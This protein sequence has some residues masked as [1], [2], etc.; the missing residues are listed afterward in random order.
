MP[1]AGRGLIPGAGGRGAGGLGGVEGGG[2][3][4]F[5]FRLNTLL[6]FRNILPDSTMPVRHRILR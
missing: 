2:V 5:I 6:L 3:A 4:R 1:L